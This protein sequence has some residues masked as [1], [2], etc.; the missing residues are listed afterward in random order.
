MRVGVKYVDRDKVQLR[1]Y[2][3][4][5]TDGRSSQPNGIRRNLAQVLCSFNW[6]ITKKLSVGNHVYLS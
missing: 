3:H 5:K 1:V 4:G 2:N 6:Y